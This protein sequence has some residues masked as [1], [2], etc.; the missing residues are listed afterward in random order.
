MNQYTLFSLSTHP[1]N[2][3]VFQYAQM[4]VISF[5]EET[6]YIFLSQSAIIMAFIIAEYCKYFP[7]AKQKFKELPELHQYLIDSYNFNFRGNE[8]EVSGIRA[9]Y[10]DE[11]QLEYEKLL[12]QQ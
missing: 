8:Y 6:A 7:I 10:E 12:K 11:F 4:Y 1:S 2:V 3:S 9:K 5:N